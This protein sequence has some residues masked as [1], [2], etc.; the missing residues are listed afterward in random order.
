MVVSVETPEGH[1]FITARGIGSTDEELLAIE[2][3]DSNVSDVRKREIARRA[4]A[5][6]YQ[7]RFLGAAGHA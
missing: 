4:S 2:A 7:L 3:Q 1:F 5:A 6:M